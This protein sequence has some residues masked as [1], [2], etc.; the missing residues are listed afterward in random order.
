MTLCANVC[1]SFHVSTSHCG[2]RWIFTGQK[3]K[4]GQLSGGNLSSLGWRLI[5][6]SWLGSIEE[7]NLLHNA[8]FLLTLEPN[9]HFWWELWGLSVAAGVG[10]FSALCCLMACVADVYVQFL[11]QPFPS[12]PLFIYILL[13]LLSL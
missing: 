8:G 2:G 12:Q 11:S 10:V 13:R 9:H 6:N 5:S 3:Y 4:S 7:Q 1:L